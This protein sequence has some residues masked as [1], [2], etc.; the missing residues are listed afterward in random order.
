M[1][2]EILKQCIISD[3]VVILPEIQLDRQ[4]YLKV[5]QKLEL[6]GGKWNRKHKG[7]LFEQDPIE[8]L[9]E[10]QNGKQRNLKK[11][12]QFFET[13]DD[14][15][16]ELVSFIPD[17]PLRDVLEPSAGRGAIVRA[18]QRFND[19]VP[20]YYCE[21]MELNRKMFNGK[22]QFICEDFFDLE[23]GKKYEI[24]IA[25]PPFRNNQDIDHFYKMCKVCDGIVISIMSQHWQFA[26]GKKETEFRKFLKRNNA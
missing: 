9:R 20:I 5:A 4:T 18:V 17:R 3:N 23:D 19:T 10:I 13:P 15:A 26:R 1:E 24:V 16:D 12:F 11:E 2:Q 8:L 14:L 7:F 25:N 21:L 22:A 6:I